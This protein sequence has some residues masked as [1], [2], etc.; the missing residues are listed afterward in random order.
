MVGYMLPF[1]EPYKQLSNFHG[2]TFE[3]LYIHPLDSCFKDMHI[4]LFLMQNFQLNQ[5]IQTSVKDN[6]HHRVN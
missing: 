4:I 2:L 3:R 6:M 1:Y 5:F